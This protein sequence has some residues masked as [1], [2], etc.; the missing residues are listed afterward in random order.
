M[1]RKVC[2]SRPWTS[3]IFFFSQ[4]R[5]NQLIYQHHSPAVRETAWPTFQILT[6]HAVVQRACLHLSWPV[7]ILRELML[8]CLHVCVKGTACVCT[9][10]QSFGSSVVSV[11]Q[12]SCSSMHVGGVIH[13]V[14]RKSNHLMLDLA[15]PW[16]CLGVGLH[17]TLVSKCW[18]T[19]KKTFGSNI[20]YTPIMG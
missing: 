2:A 15:C 17:I 3:S 10:C 9:G 1:E 16:V 4:A 14:I 8:H 5:M 6:L 18:L 13:G 20:C 7:A 19:K 12:L 11:S